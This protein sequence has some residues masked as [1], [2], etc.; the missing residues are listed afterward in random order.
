MMSQILAVTAINLRSIPQRLWTSLSAILASAVVVGV[1]LAFLAMANGFRATVAGAG[2]DDVAIIMR[3]GSQSEL[4]SVLSRDQ[5]RLIAQA[6]GIARRNEKPLISPEV[7]V[8]IDGVKKSTGTTVNLPMRGLDTAALAV[9][10]NIRLIAGRMFEPGRS[11]I[12]VGRGVL[13]EF[14]GFDL[15]ST[16]TYG[17]SRW[18]VVGIFD[19]QGTVFESEVWADAKVVQNLFNRGSSYQIVRARLTSSAALEKLDAYVRSEPRLRLEAKSERSY[20]AEQAQGMSKLIETLG[21]PIAI[22]MAIGALAGALNT[23][24]ASVAAR[25]REIGTL[26]AIGFGGLATF[27]GTLAES[28]LLTAAGGVIGAVAAVALFQNM[29]ATTLGSS[30]TQVV[31]RFELTPELVLQG[32]TLAI[33]VGLL[34]GIF[35]AF[36]A[37]RI[38]VVV[39]FAER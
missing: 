16:L 24:Y 10:D 17:N 37:A 35:P 18:T 26:R 8:I 21:W 6:P 20:L 36:R 14:A 11:E 30:F 28:L 4:N 25:T 23:M 5:I 22:T 1:L 3:P 15:G 29:T 9:R 34:G 19:A 2:A 7:Y 13:E 33:V 27:V 31:F 38:P 12:V 32:V 39:A